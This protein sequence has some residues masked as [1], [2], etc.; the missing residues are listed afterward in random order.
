MTVWAT[1]ADVLESWV[2]GN[3]P[4]DPALVERWI[5]DAEVVI[6]HEVPDVDERVAAETNPLPLDRLRVVVVRM[7]TRA[8][9]NP[10]RLRQEQD[11]AGPFSGS[12]TSADPRPGDLYLTAEDRRLLTGAGPR[13]QRAFSIS[14]VAE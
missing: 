9:K 6:R 4:D 7:V 14:T 2:G 8:L 1:A 13:R 3:R 10:D 11:A 5:A 12:R